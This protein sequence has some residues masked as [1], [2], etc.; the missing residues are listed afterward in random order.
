M[1]VYKQDIL[2]YSDTWCIPVALKKNVTGE[3][4]DPQFPT[5]EK[6]ASYAS[7]LLLDVSSYS[8]EILIQKILRIV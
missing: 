1:E 5:S 6:L 3:V 8:I 7:A 4:A 2:Q